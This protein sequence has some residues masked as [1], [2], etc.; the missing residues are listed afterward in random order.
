MAED[1]EF[2]RREPGEKSREGG[3]PLRRN[4]LLE[5]TPPEEM[6]RIQPYL[7]QEDFAFRQQLYRDGDTNQFAYFPHAGVFSM[8]SSPQEDTGMIVEIA[9]VGNEGMVGLP[10]LLG[11]GNSPGE[12]FCQVAGQSGRI[13]RQAFE[14]LVEEC[15][16]FHRVLLRYTQSLITQISQNAACNRMH[17]VEER[18]ARWLLMTQDRVGADHFELTQEFL[19][20]M[21]GVRRPTVSVAAGILQRA[22]LIAY[23][24][25]LVVITNRRGL[26]AASCSCYRIIREEFLRLTG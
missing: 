16:V 22:G 15:P 8:T 21:L 25:G 20:Q 11:G 19:A 9:T 17:P 13:P 10:L 5:L 14:R 6:E 18:C 1:M 2:A 24:R 26:E 23:S 3:N 7:E 4:R 12:C